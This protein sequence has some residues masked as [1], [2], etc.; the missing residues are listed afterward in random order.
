MQPPTAQLLSDRAAF[1]AQLAENSMLTIFPSHTH[2]F[3]G[4][5]HHGTAAE[6]KRWLLARH[7]L[8]IRDAA[9]FRGLTPGHFRLSTRP[10]TDNQL[11]IN[12]L[13][14]WTDLPA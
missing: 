5:L 13:R 9:N 12:A 10:A 11:L 14:E 4:H 3:L 7:G 1:S 6:L 8:L 2:Y